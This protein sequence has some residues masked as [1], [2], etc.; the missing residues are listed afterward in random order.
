MR[1]SAAA[2]TA[3]L[4]GIGA[5]GRPG[6]VPGVE[7][8]AAAVGEFSAA[9]DRRRGGFGSAPRFPRPSELLF[10]LRE[11]ARSGS[12]Q[13]REM[14]VRTLE[15]M[16][17]GGMRDHLG[18]GFHRYSVDADWRVPHF[19]KMLYDQAQLALAYLEAA[20]LTGE[21]FHREVA[22]DTLAYVARD[23]TDAGGGFY[24]AEDADSIPPEQD[25]GH[26]GVGPQPGG[27]S[28]HKT[29]GAFYLWTWDEIGSLCGAD[30]ELV[31]ARFGVEPDGNAPFDPHA[32]FT[33][34]NLLYAART[35]QDLATAFSTTA[36]DVTQRLER[37]R[38]RL[39][40][41][42]AGR[43]RPHLDD[44]ILTAWNGLMIAAFARGARVLGRVDHLRAARRAAAFVRE[45]LW[46]P[47][48]RTLLRRFRDG[49]AAIAGYA[50][51]YA[52]LIFGLLEL[53]QVDGDPGW[54]SWAIDLQR[55]Q[56]ELFWDEDGGGWFSTSCADPSVLIRL[57]EDYDG[58]EPSA[59][60]VGAMNLLVL[61]HLTGDPP[62]SARLE[63]AVGAFATRVETAGRSVP[64][65]LAALSACH[66]GVQQIVIVGRRDDERTW[67]LTGAL[68][69]RYLPFAV[70]LIVEPGEQQQRLAAMSPPIGAMTMLEGRPT[71]YVCRDFVCLAPAT[72]VESLAAALRVS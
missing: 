23:M 43:P 19:E 57:K 44:K 13:A 49:E 70:S 15:A 9:F 6:P 64:L 46:Q 54:L 38:P 22:D 50:D 21:A 25:D 12:A 68:A 52:F 24:S 59:T 53:F 40:E 39:F 72:D 3:Q 10:L 47:A 31:R 60:A 4:R 48:T 62:W 14:T 66:A 30:A 18:G 56:D 34:K 28:A 2:L 11:H 65:M 8:L 36:E 16:A 67:Q 1:Q 58:A 29:E 5:G 41:H 63:R 7:A 55:R 17:L 20:Q 42:R 27:S 71:A 45:R 37:A 69:A 51:D 35:A 32:E 61:A 33:G 26:R